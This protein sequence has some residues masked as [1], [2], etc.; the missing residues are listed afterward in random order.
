MKKI[1]VDAGHGG[2]DPGAV[3]G[4]RMEKNDNLNMALAVQKKLQEQGQRV[5]MTRNTDTF[6]PLEERSAI[7]NRNNADIFVSI[8][9]NAFSNISANGVETFTQINAPPINVIY[10]RK[11]HENIVAAGVQSDRGLK[12]ADFSVLRNTA[13]PAMLTELGFITNARDNQ[14]FDQNFN[15][16]ANAIARGILEA[17]GEPYYPV[18]PP[19]TGGDPVIASIQRTLNERYNTGLAVDGVFGPNTRRALVIGLQTELNRM[20]GAGL[21]IDGILGA[22][23]MAAIR[24]VRMGDRGNLVYIL[25]AALYLNGYSPGVLDG[26]FGAV[27]DAAVRTFQ[28]NNGL[29]ADGIAGPNTF[30]ALLR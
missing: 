13:A 14:L 26:I 22:R 18:L 30:G 3:S 6:V 16:Y 9:R 19:T 17:L 1:V 20:F 29:V 8:H 25:Q 7:S 4:T 24:N 11:V 5:I 27:T 23:T 21:V 2:F 12:Q 10:A 28:R 15:A